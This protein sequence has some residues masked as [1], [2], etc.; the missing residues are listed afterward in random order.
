VGHRPPAAFAALSADVR[1]AIWRDA[2]RRAT[3]GRRRASPASEAWHVT[4]FAAAGRLSHVFRA[5]RDPRALADPSRAACHRIWALLLQQAVW[6][7]PAPMIS[8]EG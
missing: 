8:P 3:G 2:I 6:R 1:Q 5:P 7:A 4:A